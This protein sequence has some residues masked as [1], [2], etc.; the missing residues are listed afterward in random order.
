MKKKRLKTVI[1]CPSSH[2][3]YRDLV[4]ATHKEDTMSDLIHTPGNDVGFR[5]DIKARHIIN[6]RPLDGVMESFGVPQGLEE[7]IFSS[8]TGVFVEEA[9]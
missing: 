9:V 8:D 3:E 6:V 5:F 1:H 4:V 2:D 7:E